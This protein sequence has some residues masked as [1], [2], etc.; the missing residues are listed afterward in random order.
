M[1][2]APTF[3]I[4]TCRRFQHAS[5]ERERTKRYPVIDLS[6]SISTSLTSRNRL[7]SSTM[8]ERLTE[9]AEIP[10]QFVKEGS[11][12][13]NRCTKPSADEYK[14]LCRAVAIGFGVMGVIG[15]LV[16]LIHIPM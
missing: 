4:S 1:L 14:Q 6:Y 16:K 3:I 12:F 13:V 7:S 8:S 15:Y 10:R 2:L 5:N 11:L 9:F